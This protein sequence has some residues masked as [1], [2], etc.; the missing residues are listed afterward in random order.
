MANTSDLLSITCPY[1]HVIRLLLNVS[2]SITEIPFWVAVAV[3]TF[4]TESFDYI[5]TIEKIKSRW[6][7]LAFKALYYLIQ[8]PQ[9]KPISYSSHSHI[10]HSGRQNWLL[11]VGK[12]G[13]SLK[14]SPAFFP[15]LPKSHPAFKTQIKCFP[16]PMP[17]FSSLHKAWTYIHCISVQ[18]KTIFLICSFIVAVSYMSHIPY[19]MNL[20]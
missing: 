19:Y 1:S 18:F 12:G 9:S 20:W 8:I 10:L 2:C 16:E 5:I 11:D 3:S 14:L 17:L 13:E 7:S 4:L 15:I 6:L